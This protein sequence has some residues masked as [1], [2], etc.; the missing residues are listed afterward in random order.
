MV[1]MCMR[2]HVGLQ[3]AMAL[4]EGGRIGRLAA[5][6]AMVG[7]HFPHARPDYKQVYYSQ[8]SGAFDL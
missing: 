8:Y 7:E 3:R 5:I 2:Y 6:R 4:V 1:G